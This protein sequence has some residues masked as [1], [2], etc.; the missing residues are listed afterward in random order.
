MTKLCPYNCEGTTT[1]VH[2]NNAEWP[3]HH[4]VDKESK[5][6]R[7]K[8]ILP[9]KTAWDFSRKEECDSI[10]RKWQMYF[11]ASDYKGRNFLELNDNNGNP[12]CPSYSKGGA[13]LKHFSLFNLLCACITRLI[14]NH[15]PIGEYRQRFFPNKL[16]A[17]PCGNY[18]LETREYILYDCEQHKQSWNPKQE[19]LKD[20]LTFLDSNPGTFCFQ[21][22]IT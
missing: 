22:G 18:P 15:A 6:H 2:F 4:L 5:T 13:R 10:V 20:V 21:E 9:S 19:S 7:I 12:I 17:C 11:Q 8:P 14:T 1:T 16:V 3:P